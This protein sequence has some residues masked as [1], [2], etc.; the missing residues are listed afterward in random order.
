MAETFLALWLEIDIAVHAQVLQACDGELRSRFPAP[1]CVYCVLLDLHRL[2]TISTVVESME[3]SWLTL[4]A[5]GKYLQFAIK[6][7]VIPI[8]LCY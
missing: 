5:L 1:L 7:L 6:M 4:D 8:S 3:G 2:C